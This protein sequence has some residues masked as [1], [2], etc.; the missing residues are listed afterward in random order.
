MSSANPFD[1]EMKRAALAMTKTW[2]QVTQQMLDWWL[3]EM[4]LQKCKLIHDFFLYKQNVRWLGSL[5]QVQTG[6]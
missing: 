3:V 4:V 1:M 2:P 5:A 6:H